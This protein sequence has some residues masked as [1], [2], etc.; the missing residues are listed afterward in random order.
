MI[1]KYLAVAYHGQGKSDI[2]AEHLRNKEKLIELGVYTPN[3]QGAG[4][5]KT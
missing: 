3:E 4:S 2:E 5:K 1:E